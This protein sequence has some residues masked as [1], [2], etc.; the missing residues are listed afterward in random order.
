MASVKVVPN[1]RRPR[2]GNRRHQ[3][4]GPTLLEMRGK[5]KPIIASVRGSATERNAQYRQKPYN[6]IK[7]DCARARAGRRNG[8]GRFHDSIVTIITV[9]SIFLP[10]AYGTRRSNQ[11]EFKK[12][13]WSLLHSGYQGV[14]VERDEYA[15]W[16]QLSEVWAGLLR[17][18]RRSTV[19]ASP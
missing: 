16:P 7:E 11:K 15:A 19:R 13:F 8:N 5:P 14:S 10:S 9:T 18:R 2:G 3:Q 4:S 12:L 17:R 1:I 6:D